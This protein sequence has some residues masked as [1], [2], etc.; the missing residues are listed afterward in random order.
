MRLHRPRVRGM[1]GPVEVVREAAQAL[2][3][4]RQ[5]EAGRR[6]R[7]D[8]DGVHAR[9]MIPGPIAHVNR[10]SDRAR[11][12]LPPAHASAR[13][14]GPC[15][16]ASRSSPPSASR[17]PRPAA[18]PTSSTRWRARSASSAPTAIGAGRRL[19]AALP[20]RPGSRR[21]S[22]APTILRVPDPRAPAGQQ[23]GRRSSTSPAD[24]YRLRLVDHP[25]AF[26]R[27]GFYGDAAGDYPDN[28]WRFGLFCRA[29]LE[30]LRADARPVDVL[31][32][33]DWHT[34]PAAIF[35]DARYADD[36]IVGGRRDPAD[37]PQPRLPRLDAAERPRAAR[38][39]ARRRRRPARRGWGRPAARRASSAPSS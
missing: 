39:A 15:R 6:D 12:A 3:A 1:P 18:W 23:H 27:D 32:L 16:C 7:R 21:R 31:H 20:R 30:A 4:G 8:A 24:G 22:S 28:A 29:A 36:P 14:I 5:R 34:G 33:H 26:D 13:T 9:G 11:A 38:A 10:F 37:A 35:R 19:P 2:E 17:G 25:A